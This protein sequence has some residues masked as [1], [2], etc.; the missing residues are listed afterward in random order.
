MRGHV[1]VTRCAMFLTAPN[2]ATPDALQ[3]F[4]RLFEPTCDR[5]VLVTAR[6]RPRPRV[7]AAERAETRPLEER[8]VGFEVSSGRV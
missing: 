6:V 5:V 8:A 7:P 2:Q 1:L 4:E 3:R